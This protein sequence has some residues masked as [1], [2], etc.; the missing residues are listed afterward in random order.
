MSPFVV[1]DKV[2]SKRVG[3]RPS[4]TG[5]VHDVF[6]SK[7]GRWC[8]DVIDAKGRMCLRSAEELKA[9]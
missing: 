5:W 7:G 6:L 4:F 8:Y 1:G 9:V 2:R 3:L